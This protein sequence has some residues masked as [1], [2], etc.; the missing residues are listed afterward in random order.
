MYKWYEKANICVAFVED[1]EVGPDYSALSRC[2][3]FTRGWT[4]QELLAPKVCQFCDKHWASFGT[5]YS[6]AQEISLI[7]GIP[8]PYLRN[9]RPIHDACVAQRMFWASRR[10][11]TR[12]EDVAYSML[13]MFD[14]NMPLLYGEGGLRAFDRLQRQILT[15]PR[16][17]TIFC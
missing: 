5:R 2:R 12:P 14:A 11:T 6:L 8:R 9:E 16:D 10:H 13:G 7:T 15:Q 1:F 3:W 4:L 17:D